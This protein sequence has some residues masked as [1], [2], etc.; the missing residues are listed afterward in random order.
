MSVLYYIN[1]LWKDIE[2]TNN[3]VYEEREV[4]LEGEC[5]VYFVF[6]ELN[7]VDV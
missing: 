7:H 4:E 6:G 5:T 3:I 1:Y 2:K